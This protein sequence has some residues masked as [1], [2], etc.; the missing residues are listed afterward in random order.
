SG[1]AGIGRPLQP[2]RRTR[3]IVL[4]PDVGGEG[5]DSGQQKIRC[6]DRAAR[7][8]IY[9][10][11]MIQIC[12]KSRIYVADELLGEEEIAKLLRLTHGAGSESETG[13]SFELPL[14]ADP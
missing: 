1:K 6:P 5:G 8:P 14:E 10:V 3:R 4:M 2:A 9:D 11:Q 7:R 12:R 13:R